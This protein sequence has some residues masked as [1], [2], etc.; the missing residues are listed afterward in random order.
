MNFIITD[1]TYPQSIENEVN[2]A[3][4]FYPELHATPIDFKF[5]SKIEKSTMQ[6]QP[7]FHTLFLP[8]S[9]RSYNIYIRN[10]FK[11]NS[12]ELPILDIPKDVL[13]GWFGHEL[14]HIMD[15]ENMGNASLIK[16]GLA[17]F[18]S[19]KAVVR[20]ERRADSFAVK[21]GMLP[22]LEKTK[23]FLL[24]HADI[25]EVYKLRL[26]ALYPSTE[27]LANMVNDFP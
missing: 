17:Y 14:G 27:E 6:A 15:Y 25:P 20:A 8:R 23:A 19:N 11:L 12:R 26:K 21:H 1:K 18:F 5:K 4:S 3:L 10:T 13:V 2:K 22:Y 7:K 16:F 9:K 24:D